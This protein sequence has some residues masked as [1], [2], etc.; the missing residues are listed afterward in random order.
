MAFNWIS[1]DWWKARC[2]WSTRLG[3]VRTCGSWV[4]NLR[5]IAYGTLCYNLDLTF[6]ISGWFV[7]T[8]MRSKAFALLQPTNQV[9]WI[10]HTHTHRAVAPVCIREQS[11]CTVAMTER[12]VSNAD[13]IHGTRKP[14]QTKQAAS[15]WSRYTGFTRHTHTHTAPQKSGR[16]DGSLWPLG[17]R[18]K[19]MT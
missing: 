17:W 10:P 14:K 1:T 3:P 12:L 6:S 2:R 15:P 5:D 11:I 18:A 16:V 4:S 13:Q 7:G 8:V 19:C 9:Y